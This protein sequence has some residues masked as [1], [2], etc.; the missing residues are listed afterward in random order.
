M[1]NNKFASV[2]I[3]QDVKALD[4]EFE[5]ISL[6]EVKVG[7]R[8]FVPFGNRIL[9]GFVVSI[10]EKS[11][12]DISK[13]KC[14]S[15]IIDTEPVIKTEMLKLMRFMCEKY[16]LKMTSILRLFLPSEMREGKV[17]ELYTSYV[18]LNCK[19]L[20]VS[21]KA[22]KQIE[23]IEFLKTN[24]RTKKS[25][26]LSKF[27]SAVLNELL[28]KNIITIEHEQINRVPFFENINDKKVELT[29]LQKNAVD[30]INECKTYLLH[31]VT[32][33]G[34]T[35]VYMSIIEKALKQ[36]KNAIM[37]VPEISLTPQVMANFKARFGD[38]VAVL[39]SSLSAGEKY[40]EWKRIFTEQARVVIGARS[41]IFAPVENVGVIIIDEEHEQSYIS[42]SNPR[43]NTQDI[44]KFRANYNHCPLV[45]GSATPSIESYAKA[46]DGE[47][48]LLEMPERVNKRPMPNI[49]IVDMMLELRL[50]NNEI[51]STRMISELANVINSNKQAMIFINRRGFSSFQMC[52]ECG[53]VASC[54]SCDAKLVYHKED[55]FLKCHF[56]GKK[57]KPLTN[58]P[59][60]HS[61][62]LKMGAVGTE[63]VVETLK[64]FFPSVK[65]LRM[66]ADTTSKKNSHQKILTEFKNT[67]PCILVGTQ[68]IAKGH[69]FE[70]VIFVGIVDADQ[71]LFQADY[72][73]AMRT[74]QLITQV[75]GRAGRSNNEGRVLLQTYA[76]K[77]YVYKFAQR[78]DYRGFFEKEVSLRK[79]TNFPPYS[80]IIRILFVSQDENK[81]IADVKNVYTKIKQ[82]KE[83]YL[84]SF[85]FL[86][87]M[88]SPI[89][90]MQNKF[91][92]QI[93]MRLRLKDIDNLEKEIYNCCD[94]VKTSMF[95]ETNPT[96]LS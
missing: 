58:C 54:I 36:N 50:G 64:K 70:D 31:G 24:G 76:P 25:E 66:D 90:K 87:A 73:S 44:A 69:D 20:E 85:I 77:H 17:K 61:T 45:L 11:N 89:K 52:R 53:Y 4:K 72:R 57:Y 40:D 51:F 62:N 19:E 43:Y 56:C 74:F 1:E 86:D 68:M 29:P 49:E 33:S 88:K 93:L 13:L 27:S 46:L 96:N 79:A 78:Y 14:I 28:K 5:Y 94:E 84:D 21:Q 10:N 75:A 12:Y 23:L 48:Q 65:V 35:E 18:K 83:K 3:D 55:N 2:V 38:K 6:P 71:S 92:Y 15:S 81:V 30:N 59:K 41:A 67:K 8:V 42:E 37:L 47:Y 22:K 39:H 60:C 32:G 80:K 9:Q 7:Q 82:L 26:V 34:K 16:H 95:F 63:R 91:R